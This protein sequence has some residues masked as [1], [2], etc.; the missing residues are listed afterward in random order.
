MTTEVFTET[1]LYVIALG[2]I[3]AYTIR[4]LYLGDEV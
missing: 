1:F 4:R 2:A 3:L